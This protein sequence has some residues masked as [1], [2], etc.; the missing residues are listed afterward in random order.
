MKFL[1]QLDSSK[2]CLDPSRS[3]L[4]LMQRAGRCS[5]ARASD[6]RARRNDRSGGSVSLEAAVFIMSSP[7]MTGCRRG[8]RLA[9][10]P[11]GEA[12]QATCAAT[13]ADHAERPAQPN[14]A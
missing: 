12:K 14:G 9:A 8:P 1:Q 11:T 10:R 4:P 13:N 7:I 3:R 5:P 2:A 6:R